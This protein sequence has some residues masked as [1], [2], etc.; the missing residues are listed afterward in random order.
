MNTAS[1][2][3]IIETS[4]RFEVVSEAELNARDPDTFVLVSTHSHRLDALA[5]FAH[6]INDELDEVE[7]KRQQ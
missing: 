2:W 3:F 6:I 4:A 5:A 1:L 7:S